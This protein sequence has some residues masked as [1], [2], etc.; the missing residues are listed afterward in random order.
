MTRDSLHIALAAGGTGGHLF[1]AIAL[2][3]VLLAR[4]HQVSVLTDR[5]GARFGTN[6]Q[7]R[8]V[9]ATRLKGGLIGKVAGAFRLAAGVVS[10]A[11]HLKRDRCQLLVGFGGYPSVPPVLAAKLLGI[12]IILVEQNAVLGRANSRLA[13]WAQTVATAF[14]KVEKLGTTSHHFTGIPVRPAVVAARSE[15]YQPSVNEGRFQLLVFGGSQGAHVFADV[16]PQAC[17]LLPGNLRRR[18]QVTQQTRPE[19]E[20]SVRSTYAELGIC[21]HIATFFDDLPAHM[22][23]SHLV[24]ARAGASTI[25]EVLTIGRPAVLVPYPHAMDDHQT[26][27]ARAI[28]AAGAAWLM[29]QTAFT[30]E[31]LAGRLETLLTLPDCAAQRAATAF[32]LGRPDA[33]DSL[34]DLAESMLQAPA[35]EPKTLLRSVAS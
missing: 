16:V 6:I 31:A 1:S 10:A 28:D 2:A 26:E 19:D 13:R 4:H 23:K 14:P 7:M 34:A 32:K 5:R 20:F 9:P 25:A 30:P 17:A 35:P 21:A 22:S 33:A 27:N 8:S 11:W 18:L 29:P 3:E 15:A 24:I 12:P